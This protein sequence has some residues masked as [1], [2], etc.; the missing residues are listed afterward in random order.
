MSADLA[1]EVERLARTRRSAPPAMPAPYTWVLAPPRPRRAPPR[2]RFRPPLGW[3][4]GS[5]GELLRRVASL[6]EEVHALRDELRGR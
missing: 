1:E 4:S 5:A 6:E 3:P 2:L